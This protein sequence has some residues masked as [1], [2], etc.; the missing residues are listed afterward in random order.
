MKNEIEAQ[1]SSNTKTEIISLTHG[2]FKRRMGEI[3][4]IVD[5][6]TE[7]DNQDAEGPLAETDQLI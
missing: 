3:E 7:S 5:E 2:E 6:L 1:K 4:N